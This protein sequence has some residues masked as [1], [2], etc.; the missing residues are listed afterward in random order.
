MNINI[1]TNPTYIKQTEIIRNF[2]KCNQTKA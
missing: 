1:N 2:S